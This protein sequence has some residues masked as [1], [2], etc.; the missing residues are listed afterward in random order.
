MCQSCSPFE[1]LCNHEGAVFV[2]GFPGPPEDEPAVLFFLGS[3]QWIKG[4]THFWTFLHPN[5]RVGKGLAG[6]TTSG[7]RNTAFC[8]S[9][10]RRDE[11]NGFMNWAFL[12]RERGPFPPKA[13]PSLLPSSLISVCPASCPASSKPPVCVYP[14]L[15]SCCKVIIWRRG[16][17]LCLVCRSSLF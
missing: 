16:C 8:F 3:L 6:G 7:S 11:A 13:T 2:S 14:M 4:T 15:P 5:V 10:G 1:P 17:V 12:G 9:V